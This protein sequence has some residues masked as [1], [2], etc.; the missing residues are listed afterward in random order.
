MTAINLDNLPSEL[1][2]H[3]MFLLGRDSLE[4][5]DSC[6]KVN[7]AWNKR[8]MNSLW[9]YPSKKWGP[10]IGRQFE[11]SWDI[12]L[13]SEEIISKAV[14]LEA[15]TRLAAWI[16]N[17]PCPCLAEDAGA[18]ES[19]AAATILWERQAAIKPS[20]VRNTLSSAI[21]RAKSDRNRLE[22]FFL[23]SC[24]RTMPVGLS[25]ASAKRDRSLAT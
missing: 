7:S 21:P 20:A 11:R 9:D 19:G 22:A 5:L 6:R 1:F 17:G 15:D 3:I 18:G 2:D 16:M 12:N 13:P 25:G 8:I 4:S 24:Q 14:K 10:I 23:R